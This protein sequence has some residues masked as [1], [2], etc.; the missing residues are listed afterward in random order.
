MVEKLLAI[1][2]QTKDWLTPTA[3]LTR[4]HPPQTQASELE[5]TEQEAFFG[6]NIGRL[7]FLISALTYCEVIEHLTVNP[8]PNVDAWFSGL[9]NLR[10]D[11]V[12]VIDLHVLF[13][14]PVTT[15]KRQLFVIDRGEKAMAIWID[16][17]PQIQNMSASPLKQLPALPQLLERCVV[18]GH[19][20]A[21]QI[22]LNVQFDTL[23]KA[24]GDSYAT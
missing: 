24:L 6:F 18:S 4:F 16:G 13:A 2:E 23:F 22:W 12:P 9:L 1:S 5:Y 11:L 10:G 19:L 14:E 20:Y 7:A 21:N 17:L 8:L 15:D 3:A